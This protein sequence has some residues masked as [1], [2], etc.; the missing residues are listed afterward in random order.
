[1]EVRLNSSITYLFLPES[2]CLPFCRMETGKSENGSL[3][4]Q[5]RNFSCVVS[6]MIT[7]S[8]IRSSSDI[9]LTARWQFWSMTQCPTLMASCITAAAL[10]PWK[11]ANKCLTSSHDG[12]FKERKLH[13]CLHDL[14]SF[15]KHST[16]K[17]KGFLHHLKCTY[18]TLYTVP[19]HFE[20]YCFL[21]QL[22]T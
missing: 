16:S 13:T 2:H 11:Y 19:S 5:S 7:S 22:N 6:G 4:S 18:A 17:K 3:V 20:R 10:E 12:G 9:Q 15:S 1:M 21:P 8:H 14:I